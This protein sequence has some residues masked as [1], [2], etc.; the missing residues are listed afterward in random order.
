MLGG[1]SPGVEERSLGRGT[2]GEPCHWG[3]SQAK[4]PGLA[5]DPAHRSP[6]QVALS[7]IYGPLRGPLISMVVAS[8]GR[9]WVGKKKSESR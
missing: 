1:L 5:D 7:N 6:L 3:R 2:A 4:W 9:Q 8:N